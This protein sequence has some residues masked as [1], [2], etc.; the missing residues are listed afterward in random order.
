MTENKIGIIIDENFT[1]KH[2][3]PYPKPTFISFE[4][5]I[6][7]KTILD[8]LKKELIYQKKNIIKISPPE[9]EDDIIELAH[10]KFHIETMRKISQSGGGIIDEEVFVTQDSFSLAK[11]A[12]SGAISA[13]EKLLNKEVNQTI[14]LIRPP[15]HHAFRSKPSGL[16][17]FNNIAIATYYVRQMLSYSKKIAIIDIDNHFGDGLAH[18][19]YEDPS[20]LYISIHEFDFSQAEIGFIDEIGAGEGIGTNIN[21]PVPEGLASEDFFD[22]FDFIDPIIREFSPGILIIAA[23]FDMYFADPIG[24]GL[25]TSSSYYNF[26]KKVLNLAYEICDGQLSFIL[27]GG[28][29]V[30]GLRYCILAII[31]ALLNEPYNPPEFEA[32]FQFESS[33]QNEIEKIKKA[34]IQTIKP[35]WNC[36]KVK[37]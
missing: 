28:Y 25:L 12:A 32:S 19:F 17:I 33:H 3:P 26:A 13:I 27:E 8:A 30:I 24:N 10:S 36:L 9:I 21:F 1:L 35:Y 15:G 18:Y 31:K 22:F 14:A 11:K 2:V 5:P 7:I 34:I 29:S 4:H 6:R 23:G 37:D 20:V 16:C